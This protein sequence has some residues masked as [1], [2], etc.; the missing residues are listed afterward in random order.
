MRPTSTDFFYEVTIYVEQST[1]TVVNVMN[2]EVKILIML[3][4]MSIVTKGQCVVSFNEKQS[5][6]FFIF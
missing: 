2:E 5:H 6:R 3:L 4:N 1:G